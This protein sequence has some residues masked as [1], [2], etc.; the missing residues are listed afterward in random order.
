[1]G[2]Q[3]LINPLSPSNDEKDTLIKTYSSRIS[4]LGL[5]GPAYRKN[6]K[7]FLS[8]IHIIPIVEKK[9]ANANKTIRLIEVLGAVNEENISLSCCISSPFIIISVDPRVSFFVPLMMTPTYDD[10]FTN[11][12]HHSFIHSFLTQSDLFG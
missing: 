4:L 10:R 12:V 9:K 11:C 1:M 5:L 2:R 7:Q 6:S 8:Q 3:S